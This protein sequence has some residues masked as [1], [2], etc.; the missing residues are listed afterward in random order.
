MDTRVPISRSSSYPS[1]SSRGLQTTTATATRV[2]ARSPASDG[3]HASGRQ[4]SKALGGRRNSDDN[5]SVVSDISYD[6]SS[7]LGG[8]RGSK[9]SVLASGVEPQQHGKKHQAHKRY[10][11]FECPPLFLPLSLSYLSLPIILI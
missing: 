5:H 10:M 1:E 3:Y 8:R 6:A 4:A 2:V 11:F 7:T 9:V